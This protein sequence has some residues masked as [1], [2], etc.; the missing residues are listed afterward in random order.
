MPENAPDEHAYSGLPGAFRYA[1]RTSGS[2]AFRLYTVVSAIAGLVILTLLALGLVTWLG[3]PTGLVGE[4]ALLGVIAIFLLA[5]LFAPVLLVARRTR[6][7]GPDA[8]YDRALA[9]AGIA[10]VASIYVGLVITVPE[11]WQ[12]SP[13]GLLAPVVEFLY[14]LPATWG[15]GPPILGVALIVLAH[16]LAR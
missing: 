16:R 6:K 9:L 2:L 1:F 12:E 11:Q 15:F 4:R 7:A 3:N 14:H 13:S 8:T 5:P 10:F